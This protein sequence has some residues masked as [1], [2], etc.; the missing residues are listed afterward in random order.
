[1]KTFHYLLSMIMIMVFV[2]C[3][4]NHPVSAPNLSTEA[5]LPQAQP[6]RDYEFQMGDVFDVTFFENPELDQSVT[7]RPDGRISLPLVEDLFVVG[8]TPSALDEIITRRYQ[9]KIKEPEVTIILRQFAGQRVYVAGEVYNPGVL[10]LT[11]GMT[12]LKSIFNAGGFKRSAKLNSVVVIRNNDNRPEFHR[13]DVDKILDK[14]GH[15]FALRPYDVV[16]VPKTFIARADD[17]VDQYINDILP[18]AMK[19]GFSFIYQLNRK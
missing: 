9:E 18:D 10:H 17:F 13:V 12:L 8:M 14:G 1:M 16:Y 5:S 4:A 15:D 19:F 2:G 6:L 3:A 7:V 11:G